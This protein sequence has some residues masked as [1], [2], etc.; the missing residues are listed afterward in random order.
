MINNIGIGWQLHDRTGWG[1]YGINL[2]LQLLSRPGYSPTLLFPPGQ[3]PDHPLQ[4]EKLLPLIETYNNLANALKLFPEFKPPSEKLTVRYGLGNNF[5]HN[6]APLTSPDKAGIIF[7]ENTLFNRQGRER[8]DLFPLIITGSHWNQEILQNNRFSSRIETVIQ[9]IDPTIFHPA[10]KSGLFK[11]RFVIFSGGKLEY[12]KGQDIVIAAFRIF[13]KC[14]PETLLLAAW[15]NSW[16]ES[17]AKITTKGYVSGLP[18]TNGNQQQAIAKWLLGNGLSE[19]CFLLLPETPNIYM[20]P[21]IREADV[22]LFPNRGEGGTNM[23]A[24]TCSALPQ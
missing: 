21:I 6:D 23:A 9:G 20:A 3:L 7:F 2:A 13:Q 15:H 22:A 8:A 1:I 14:H 17:M 10:P 16:P 11:N 24:P 12:R 19:G 4:K 18:A 5:V